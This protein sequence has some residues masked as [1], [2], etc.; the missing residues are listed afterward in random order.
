VFAAVRQ[1]SP[2]ETQPVS[3]EQTTRREEQS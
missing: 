2:Q 1:P 3:T